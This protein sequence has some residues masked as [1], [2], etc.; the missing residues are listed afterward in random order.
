MEFGA[1]VSELRQAIAQI[2]DD[3][4]LKGV[5]LEAIYGSLTYFLG[6]VNTIA[7]QEK[8]TLP[9]DRHSEINALLNQLNSDANRAFERLDY[10]TKNPQ[11]VYTGTK[12]KTPVEPPL[13]ATL[14]TANLGGASDPKEIEHR[15]E[16]PVQKAGELNAS[17]PFNTVQAPEKPNQINE[18][19]LLNA[20]Y[21]KIHTEFDRILQNPNLI[22]VARSD[23]NSD[24]DSNGSNESVE[25]KT[26]AVQ[27]QISPPQ[28]VNV[29]G[30]GKK[31][32]FAPQQP[33]FQMRFEGFQL[34]T[35]SGD[36]TEWISFRDEFTQM[37]HTNPEATDIV[38]FQQLKTHLRGIALDAI[39][40]F[41]LCAADYHAAWA[42]LV[43]RYDNDHRIVTEYIKKFFD[44]PLLGPN[45]S[46]TEFLQMINRT[47]QL[48]RVLPSFGYDVTS[49]DPIIMYCLLARLDAKQIG[50]WNGQ[51]KMRQRVPLSEMM[52]F[53]EVQAAEIVAS[54]TDRPRFVPSAP[55]NKFAG[56]KGKK[57][58]VMVT[59]NDEP[60]K[61]QQ[62]KCAQCGN[63]HLTFFCKT[64]LALS[65]QDRI[66][67]IR[68]AKHCFRCLNKHGKDT[69]CNFRVCKHCEKEH[70]DILCLQFENKK[71]EQANQPASQDE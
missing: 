6:R 53:L 57:A 67:T 47:N 15:V 43:Q 39:N 16:E 36:Y 40:G 63:D 32:D 41:K 4:G 33:K 61:V 71:K 26:G 7:L 23:R 14:P 66:K 2:L 50:K 58:H 22:Q 69:P 3:K 25:G 12:P 60:K 46:N 68:A 48:I 38:K 18:E 9:S 64:F 1:A 8:Q 51:I 34:S 5:D 70:N 30:A 19:K 62:K 17:N 56:K 11:L 65:V 27:I 49:W 59:V 24:R 20:I 52:E 28:N 42:T 37:I 55:K 35:F 31:C 44:L 45:P 13:R 10:L 54:T 21:N 29:I